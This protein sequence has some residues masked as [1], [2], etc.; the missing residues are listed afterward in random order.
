[1]LIVDCSSNDDAATIR[2]AIIFRSAKEEKIHRLII[3]IR[4]KN[5]HHHHHIKIISEEVNLMRAPA[6]NGRLILRLSTLSSLYELFARV[7]KCLPVREYML[8]YNK[9]IKIR[10]I[11]KMIKVKKHIFSPQTAALT[12]ICD[13]RMVK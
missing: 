7:H 10:L 2:L 8:T 9:R 5:Y 1:M 13:A 6:R 3:N 12:R 11:T 4:K